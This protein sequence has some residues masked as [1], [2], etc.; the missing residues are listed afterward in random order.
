MSEAHESIL[1]GCPD[2]TGPVP[3]A[4]SQREATPDEVGQDALQRS[5]P[6]RYR[7]MALIGLAAVITILLRL[8]PLG[9]WLTDFHHLRATL[10]EGDLWAEMLFLLLTAALTAA[11]AP[12][13]M[14]YTLAGLTFEFWKGLLLA[15]IGAL[16]GA[17]TT[18]LCVRWGGRVFVTEWF[19]RYPAGR[20]VLALQ[21]SIWSVLM[22][23]QLPLSG[24]VVNVGL[25]LSRVRSVSFLLGSF[26]GFLPQ[27]VIVTLVGSGLAED[28]AWEAI[29]QLFVAAMMVLLGGIW[30]GRKALSG[31]K[32]GE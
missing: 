9:R 29:A 31:T 24:L 20:K 19:M 4:C 22:I 5:L 17:Y 8:T 28:H 14:F 23:R 12:R 6:D 3:D 26:L 13:L 27:G 32:H 16:A 11:G 30:L 18:Y 25:G 21:P 1:S 15:Q 7:L 10:D 2:V